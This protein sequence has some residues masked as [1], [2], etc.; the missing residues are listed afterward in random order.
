MLLYGPPGTGKTH[1]C[2]ALA[3][4]AG[5]CFVN[6]TPPTPLTLLTL[7]TLLSLRVGACF[8]NLTRA[9]VASKWYGET[10]KMVRA[11]PTIATLTGATLTMATLTLGALYSTH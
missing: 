6:L 11:I 10:E 1:I 9:S 3:A 7:L 2:R 8:I 4:E 5:A